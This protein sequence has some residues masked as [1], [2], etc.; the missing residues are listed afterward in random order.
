MAK[1]NDG[2]GDLVRGTLS[3]LMAAWA[4][5]RAAALLSDATIGAAGSGAAG[6][7]RRPHGSDP[8]EDWLL[9][10]DRFMLGGTSDETLSWPLAAGAGALYGALRGRLPGADA[11]SGV[12]FGAGLYVAASKGEK[13]ARGALP[14]VLYGTTAELAMRGLEKISK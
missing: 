3:G 5:N 4:M 14:W 12:L 2:I 8:G 6:A 7:P 11:A 13:S 9:G 10:V 1:A